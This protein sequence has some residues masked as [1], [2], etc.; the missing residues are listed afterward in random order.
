MEQIRIHACRN[1]R[2]YLGKHILSTAGLFSLCS[3]HVLAQNGP[4]LV[5]VP[6]EFRTAPFDTDRYLNLTP[7]FTISVCARVPGAR[8]MAVAPDGDILVSQP[9]AG[10]IL[11]LQ[12][13]DNGNPAVSVF[14]PGLRLPH[15]MVFHRIGETMYLYVA[16]SDQIDRFVYNWQDRAAHDREVLISGLPSAS[17]SELRGAYAHELKNIAIDS[18][19]RIYVS[20][21]SA[22]NADPSDRLATPMRGAIYQ[23]QADGSGARLFAAGLRNAEGLRFL[24]GTDTL[25]AAV[26][27]RDNIAYPFSNNASLYGQVF[28]TYVDSHPPDEFTAVRDGGDYGWPYANPD[29]DTGSGLDYTP[30]DP[31]FENNRDGL[32]FPITNFDRIS[33]GIAAHS[34]PLGLTFLQDTVFPDA[35]RQG[36]LIALHGSWNRSRFTG[37]KVIY[38]PWDSANQ[39]PGPQMDM[40]TGW[41]EDNAHQSWGRPVATVIDQS[42]NLLISDD[43]SGT[44]Y[45]ISSVPAVSFDSRTVSVRA[46]NSGKCVQV[47]SS[48]SENGGPIVQQTCDG[49][50]GQLWTFTSRNPGTYSLT[51]AGSTQSLDVTGGPE[52]VANG[53]P[54]QQWQYW[55][56]DNQKFRLI[57]LANG[58]INIVA[59]NSGKC[60]DVTGGPA[61]VDDGIPLQQWACW[62]GENQNFHLVD[63]GR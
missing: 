13:Q 48:S 8:F 17:S 2:R 60:L 30:F 50:A 22:T 33:K 29:P 38:F 1:R 4:V 34:A 19:H 32:L 55:G 5:Q 37:Y 62:G 7:Q 26:N 58:S 36:A 63:A 24:P 35:Y 47:L 23:Y 31:D 45:K 46:D 42:G 25:W 10:N 16:E 52:A 61:A 12:S 28:P 3:L 54:F 56:G 40:V 27:N 44:I 21:G 41:L 20:I 43:T 11:L 57:P 53:T 15:D 51:A 9:W 18:A 39:V 59:N 14:A 6:A 49:S